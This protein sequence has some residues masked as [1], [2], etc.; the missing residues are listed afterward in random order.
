MTEEY[1]REKAEAETKAESIMREKAKVIDRARA[2][3]EAKARAED[4]MRKQVWREKSLGLIN[5]INRSYETRGVN[6][7]TKSAVSESQ[8]RAME[9]TDIKRIVKRT[10]A[11]AKAKKR[12]IPKS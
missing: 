4:D 11:A 7:D 12:R 1:T 3:A 6:L 9:E 5:S 8:S 10:R 2:E